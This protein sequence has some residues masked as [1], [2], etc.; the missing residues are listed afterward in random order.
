MACD[1]KPIS[2]VGRCRLI[3]GVIPILFLVA[4]Q[5]WAQDGVEV[6][7][8]G[9][10]VKL[11][12]E[13]RDGEP[14]YSVE[15]L[16]ADILSASQLGVR[17]SEGASFDT[18]L[19]LAGTENATFNETWTQVWGEKKD[20]RNNYNELRAALQT[21]G[22]TPRRMDIVFRVYDDGFGFRYEWP[23]QEHLGTFVIAEELTEFNIVGDPK[24]WWI[25]AYGRSHYEYVWREDPLS[26]IAR[27]QAVHT[28]LTMET[29]D[30]LYLSI[31]E[32]ALVDYSSMSLIPDGDGGLKADL[33]PWGGDDGF[34]LVRGRTPLVSPWRTVQ[35]ADTPG[36]LIESYLIL[37]LNEPNALD[38]TSW[39]KPA[40]YIGIWWSMHLGDWTWETGPNHGATTEHAKRYIDF[41]AE[42][43]LPN[44]LIEGWNAGWDGRWWGDGV[45]MNFT[46]PTDDF[47]LDEVMAYA[48]DRGVNIVGHH[49]T[50]G[51][52]PNYEAQL[53]DALALY[54]RHGVPSVKL[55][56]VD[57]AQGI[58]HEDADGVM[59]T[60]WHY[61]QYMVDH[62]ARARDAFARH[63]IAMNPHEP[64]KDTG[65]RRTYPHVMTREGAR[66]QEYNSP[67][68]GGNPVDYTTI[69]PFTRLLAGPMDFTPGIFDLGPDKSHHTPSTLANQ[70]A[71]YVVLYSPLQMAADL[72]EHYE[73]NLAAFQFIKDVAVD[74]DDTRVLNG[75]IGDYVTIARKERGGDNWYLG[76][77]T[78]GVG[79][80]LDAPLS[81][82]DPGRDYVAEIYRDGPRADWRSDPLD[83]GITDVIVDASTRLGLRLAPGGGQAIRFRPANDEDRAA[84]PRY[85]AVD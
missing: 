23:E 14:T 44:V 10:V 66:G 31:H 69:L 32:A 83:I 11:T 73:T 85:E 29:A 75:E 17:F 80:M 13:M 1:S 34:T 79:R 19:T 76:S 67:G 70:L 45:N 46:R 12:L 48:A 8:P 50:G 41:A 62:N 36:G 56:Y 15:R 27:N 65:L 42:H 6:V 51:A 2:A 28:P 82:L 24:V 77:I 71:L 84:I 7:S 60:E 68:G 43:D 49:E 9:G 52:V 61:G 38:D 26:G 64:V 47:D 30:R 54:S 22:D 20:I 72:P 5:S 53:E 16:G 25:P 3:A 40:K 63:R 78:D 35:I 37:N 4:T 81:F 21:G 58:E 18:G 57:F 59:R 74:W 39:I 55:G 33:A